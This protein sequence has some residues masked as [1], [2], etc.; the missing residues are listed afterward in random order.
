MNKK[1][2]SLLIIILFLLTDLSVITTTATQAE[3]TN[4]ETIY[5]DDDNIE[6]PWHGTMEYPYQYIHDA[7]ENA[8]D[9]DT[10]FV[11]N[12][13]YFVFNNFLRISRKIEKRKERVVRE[14][15]TECLETDPLGYLQM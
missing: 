2:V 6:G 7:V 8:T 13:T 14:E 9:G 11:F 15:I 1:S 10:I 12:G 5:V 4:A 3:T